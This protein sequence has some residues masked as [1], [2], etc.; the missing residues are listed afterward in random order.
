MF[1]KLRDLNLGI[2]I[3]G[4][5]AVLILIGAVMAWLGYSSLSLVG[6][7]VE[8]GNGASEID[9]FA[10]KSR[11]NEETFMLDSTEDNL[12]ETNQTLTELKE[13]ITDVQAKMEIA[14]EKE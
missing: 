12:A 13:A 10:M 5:F 8:I 3:G 11:I 1:S 4:G 9:E 2:K 7:K 14:S 6:H